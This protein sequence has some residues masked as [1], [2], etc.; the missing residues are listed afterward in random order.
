MLNC[1]EN[2]TIK[3]KLQIIWILKLIRKKGLKLTN[4]KHQQQEEKK[5]F[6]HP[7][8]KSFNSEE[9]KERGTLNSYKNNNNDNKWQS[10]NSNFLCFSFISFRLENEN[11]M[12]YFVLLHFVYKLVSMVSLYVFNLKLRYTCNT[13]IWIRMRFQFLRNRL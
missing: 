13:A 4:K 12:K 10:R 5:T 9:S 6:F 11:E 8:E 1:P 3:L 2:S 7:N